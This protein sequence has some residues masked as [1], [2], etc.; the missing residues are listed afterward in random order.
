MRI[1]FTALSF[2]VLTVCLASVPARTRGEH[3]NGGMH[4]MS[5]DMNEEAAPA[6]SDSTLGTREI[7]RRINENNLMDA[8]EDVL[9]GLLMDVTAAGVPPYSDGGTPSDLFDDTGG[10][11]V[12][13]YDLNYSAANLT[14]AAKEATTA[15]LNFLVRNPDSV[16]IDLSE[17]TP[18]NNVD[19][20]WSGGDYDNGPGVPEDGSGVLH[21][22]TLTTEGGAIAGVYPLT[23]TNNAHGDGTYGFVPLVTND[24]FVAVNTNCDVDGDG[25]A[26]DDDVCPTYPGAPDNVGCPPPG[27]PAVGGSAGL[28]DNAASAPAHEAPDDSRW[29]YVSQAASAALAI[30]VAVF[31]AQRLR[32]SRPHP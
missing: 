9:D 22:L 28:L 10:M 19:D 13:I 1:V 27:P 23:L 2:T 5:I 18:D 3:P 8:D 14:I 32:N 6:N 20:R 12:F 17:I 29:M 26:D 24:A 25:I 11:R 4:A 21:R 31:C 30:A 16:L 15:G 7:C